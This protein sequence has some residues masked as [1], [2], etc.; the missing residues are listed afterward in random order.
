MIRSFVKVTTAT[1]LIAGV[2]TP[3]LADE[4]A[5]KARQGVM[6]IYAQNLGIL[7]A[8]AKG[9]AE[10]NAEAAST[11]AGNL[12]TMMSIDQSAMW[13][14]GTD[15]ASMPAKTGALPEIWT[16]Y[17]AIA[18]KGKALADAVAAMN[19]AAGTDLASLQGA[20]GT[21]GGACGGCHKVYRQK[22]E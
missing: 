15:N 3:S 18:E 17:P 10:Y 20:I 19:E 13:P 7:G 22:D 8:M 14:Q 9:T 2:V 12:M 21:V 16:T 11:A 6:Q 1:L 4:A 5:I